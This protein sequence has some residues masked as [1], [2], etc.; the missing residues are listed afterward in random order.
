[1]PFLQDSDMPVTFSDP[2]RLPRVVN[3]LVGSQNGGADTFF[4]KLCLA[5]H[6]RGLSQKIIISPHPQREKELR[7]AG[8][9]FTVIRFG[10]FQEALARLYLRKTIRDYSPDVVIA[11]M[12]RAARRLPH[13]DFVKVAR[14]GGYYPI[15]WYRKCD[16][17]I[18]N[19][20][21]ICRHIIES[22]FPEERT[23]IITNF[24]EIADRPRIEPSL[25]DTPADRPILLCIGRLDA[26]KGY[27]LAIRAL[28]LIPAAILWLVGDGPEREHLEK[29]ASSLGVLEHI[30]FT[31]W[32]YD[33]SALFKAADVCIVPSRHE[34][35]SNVILEAWH[36]EVPVV[37][38]AC[39][40]PSWL[41]DDE[42]NGLLVPVGDHLALANAVLRIIDHEDLKAGLRLNGKRK[43]Q[44]SHS[45]EH[46]TSQYLDFFATIAYGRRFSRHPADQDQT[47][48]SEQS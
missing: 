2:R 44:D 24:G 18:G 3:L 42:V 12:N 31:G 43:L 17:L 15:K 11:W 23:K 22:G 29:L 9:D 27:D 47:Q 16:Y 8:C 48:H 36:H 6:E 21:D 14:L 32:R 34:P 10:G 13:G 20:P 35:L 1:M 19:T 41:I 40:G 39:E 37:A 33:T 4:V 46:I 38:A 28:A 5:L 26:S 45:K 7:D 30:R 25:L